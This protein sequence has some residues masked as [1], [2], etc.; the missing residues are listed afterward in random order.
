MRHASKTL[1]LLLIVLML[2]SGCSTIH[3]QSN[4]PYPISMSREIAADYTVVGHF[5][6]QTRA[7]FTLGG[8]LTFKDVD[9]DYLVTKEIL[10][11]GGDG[12][13]NVR[14]VDQMNGTDILINMA[15]SAAGGLL[16]Y[17]IT[18][19]SDGAW[20]SLLPFFLSTR[21]VTVKGDVIRRVRS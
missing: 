3:I 6:V 7:M 10:R 2:I 1:V 9:F 13:V 21:T 18:G 11:N 4:S 17:A 5:S 16:G 12:A 20:G 15:L 19:E 8:F 14:I